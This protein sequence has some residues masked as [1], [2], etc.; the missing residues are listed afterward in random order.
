MVHLLEM[1]P[2]SCRLQAQPLTLPQS[3][4]TPRPRPHHSAP[5]EKAQAIVNSMDAHAADHGPIT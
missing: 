5:L 1:S 4:T 2:E 3:P